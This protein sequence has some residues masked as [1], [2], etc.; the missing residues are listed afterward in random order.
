MKWSHWVSLRPRSL[1]WEANT[2]AEQTEANDKTR[3]FI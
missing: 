1:G 3:R 2:P